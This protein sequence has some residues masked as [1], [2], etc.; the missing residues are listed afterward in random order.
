LEISS[1]VSERP[2]QS[3]PYDDDRSGVPFL[4]FLTLF[5]LCF[6][7]GGGSRGD[8]YSLL[9]L[10]PVAV[11]CLFAFLWWSRKGDLRAVKVPLILLGLFALLLV[12]Q[13]IP[14]PPGIWMNLPGRA[15]F[16]EAATLAG[17]E[18]PWRPISLAPDLTLNSLA[19]LVVPAAALVG[20]AVLGEA[21]RR[22]LLPALLLAVLASAVFGLAQLTAG[23][24][25][26]FYLY[27]VTNEGS[28]VGLM[29]NRNH[30]A[31]L[32]AI[33][34]PMLAFWAAIPN[35]DPRARRFRALAAAC[36]GF[37]LIPM[38]LVTGSRAGLAIGGA[39]ALISILFYFNEQR[40]RGMAARGAPGLGGLA[41][42]GLGAVVVA[43]AS[44]LLSRSEALHRLL[45]LDVEGD[46]RVASLP[47]F[48]Q[49][50]RD[51]FPVGSGTGTFD[52]VYRIYEPHALLSPA[53]LN[54]AHNDLV[55]VAISSGALGLALL[56]AALIWW[57]LRSFRLYLGPRETAPAGSY[58]RLAALVM[59]LMLAASLV[60]YP[61]RTPSLAMVFAIF[62]GWL[63]AAGRPAKADLSGDG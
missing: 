44:F 2:G 12:I 60:D 16:A 6:L 17:I 59:I 5:V 13:L 11:V 1:N 54:Q 47:T 36:L 8:I 24:D 22:M 58:G 28:A 38:I 53:Y 61:L 55:D 37:F 50:A 23:P 15:P 3:G 31:L 27:D 4:L 41:V 56:A 32:L 18:Q 7:G 29:S 48:L 39:S 51:F 26:A 45:A 34:Y 35:P 42:V 21:Q 10:R 9:Y 63:S 52:P 43:A 30:Q 25:S 14:L 49:M 33:A 46:L 57:A 20:F 19:A 62:C 40:L